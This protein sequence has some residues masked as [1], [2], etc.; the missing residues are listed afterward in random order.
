MERRTYAEEDGVGARRALNKNKHV[1]TTNR[2]VCHKSEVRA[3]ERLRRPAIQKH[4]EH[5]QQQQTP[6]QHT[7]TQLQQKEHFTDIVLKTYTNA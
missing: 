4:N 6:R 1:Q 7:E 3:R 2:I 5:I